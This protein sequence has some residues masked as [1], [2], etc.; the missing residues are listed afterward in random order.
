M[1]EIAG[2][3]QAKRQEDRKRNQMDSKRRPS[4]Y[5]RVGVTSG[6]RGYFAVLYD[7]DG[8]IQSG[9]GSYK[10][11]KEAMVEAREW[12]ESEELLCDV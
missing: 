5:P 3:G 4:K 12:A 10:S 8:P 9:V 1:T 6:L 2:L 7:Q 11:A